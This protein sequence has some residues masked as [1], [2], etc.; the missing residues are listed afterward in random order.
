MFQVFV[1][2]VLAQVDDDDKD[3]SS[4]MKTNDLEISFNHL[5]TTPPGLDTFSSFWDGGWFQSVTEK[6]YLADTP[7]HVSENEAKIAIDSLLVSISTNI[8]PPVEEQGR[9]LEVLKTSINQAA[10]KP[11]WV[12]ELKNKI[13]SLPPIT[14]SLTN[15]I[16]S[17]DW[18]RFQVRLEVLMRNNLLDIGETMKHPASSDYP[19]DISGSSDLTKLYNYTIP[20]GRNMVYETLLEGK[21]THAQFVE[22]LNKTGKISCPHFCSTLLYAA[23]G[24]S[25]KLTLLTKT[26]TEFVVR[27]G[28]W[29]DDTSHIDLWTQYPVMKSVKRF[30]VTTDGDQS[31][32]MASVFGG[33]VYIGQINSSIF[34]E[35]VTFSLTGVV[36][37]PSFKFKEMT[38]VDWR[39]ERQL[40]QAPW[41][42]LVSDQLILSYPK[43]VLD[44]IQDPEEFLIH[45]ERILDG[46]NELA[47]S[48]YKSSREHIAFSRDLP[49]QGSK[50]HSGN[51][52]MIR[53]SISE[54]LTDFKQIWE[55]APNMYAILHSLAHNHEYS[56]S[57]LKF[58]SGESFVGNLFVD[59][60]K[61]I[62]HGLRPHEVRDE[63]K[64]ENIVQVVE[65]Y[66]QGGAKFDNFFS[67]GAVKLFYF[68]CVRNFGYDTVMKLGNGWNDIE[69]GNYQ[70]R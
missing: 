12:V 45:W 68:D 26:V 35:N 11:E 16:N 27:I 13:L 44:K 1:A 33:I 4:T 9:I 32:T 14:P 22:R 17:T 65:E 69:G 60:V 58:K 41:G 24:S 63:Y 15:P 54:V 70:G 21:C 20:L 61:N 37:T 36:E 49:N 8:P 40:M 31:F 39:E 34:L 59:Y 67:S 7:P 29:M 18:L 5:E 23:P 56:L 43:R 64:W 51:P 62:V 50:T 48:P 3:I 2:T 46:I 19:G 55:K 10:I 66:I 25:L 6:P 53:E 57:L 52:L 28:H 30:T 38:L 42:D 47:S